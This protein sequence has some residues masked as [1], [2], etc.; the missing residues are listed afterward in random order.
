M[1]LLEAHPRALAEFGRRV[2]LVRAHQ[3]RQPTPC[4]EWEVR[5]LVQ[6]VVVEQLWLPP[7][8]AGQTIEQ[9]GTRFDGD[10]LG[11]DPV[12]AWAAAAV[13]AE[14]AAAAPG[15]LAGTVHLS[16]GDQPA[17]HYLQEA[18]SDLVVHAWDLA[19]GIGADERLDP[20]LVELVYRDLAPRAGELAASGLFAPP[21][22]V[23]ADAD[24]QTRLLGLVGRDA[25]A[26]R[27]G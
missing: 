6:H 13:A 9:V 17:E 16:Y 19:R 23:P 15:A 12:G 5:D 10:V 1:E 25:L 14:V 26:G 11:D 2:R 22:P 20:E 27:P 8:L 3:W 24:R 4:P 18:I 7:L 21:V